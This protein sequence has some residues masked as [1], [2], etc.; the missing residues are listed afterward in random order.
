MAE[1]IGN[2]HTGVMDTATVDREAT[3]NA[4]CAA[5]GLSRAQAQALANAGP[6]PYNV[7][8]HDLPHMLGLDSATLT[9]RP[10][11]A[12]LAMAAQTSSCSYKGTLTPETLLG[13]L[14]LGQVPAEFTAHIGC[15][16]G[17][18]S[19][20]VFVLAIEQAAQQ[21]GMPISEIWRNVAQLNEALQPL[22]QRRPLAVGE[23]TNVTQFE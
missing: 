21:S 23:N 16:L 13:V 12:W 1:T 14:V 5:L 7:A 18:V 9:P 10:P 11:K 2:W 4:R 22:T 20:Q 8:P 17:E 15:F 19:A 3:I 6:F